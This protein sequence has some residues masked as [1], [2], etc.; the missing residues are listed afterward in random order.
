MSTRLA[1]GPFELDPELG[2]LA[3][4]TGQLPLAPKPFETLVYL[5]RSGARLVPKTELLENVWSGTFVTEDVLVHNC[6]GDP[7]RHRR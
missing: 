7:A 4:G 6:G 1:F 2:S 3:R 5:A